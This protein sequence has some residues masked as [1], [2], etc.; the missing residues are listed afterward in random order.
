MWRVYQT[1]LAA[2]ERNMKKTLQPARV[3]KQLTYVLD[4]NVQSHLLYLIWKKSVATKGGANYDRAL[5]SI[6]N[7]IQ[8]EWGKGRSH[9]I[10]YYQSQSP[11]RTHIRTVTEFEIR[12][13]DKHLC[14]CCNLMLRSNFL[15]SLHVLITLVMSV[16]YAENCEIIDRSR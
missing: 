13:R 10:D 12:G 9:A 6:A 16:F 2:T 3:F 14:L 7:H 11:S 1:S 4:T 8:L 15:R 5:L